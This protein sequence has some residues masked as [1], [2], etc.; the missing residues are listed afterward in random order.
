MRTEAQMDLHIK[1]R[2][3]HCACVGMVNDQQVDIEEQISLVKI[4]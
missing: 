2:K 3:P 1:Y 4:N